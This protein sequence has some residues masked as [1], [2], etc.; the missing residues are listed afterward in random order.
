MWHSRPRLCFRGVRGDS[1]RPSYFRGGLVGPDPKK[2][3]RGLQSALLLALETSPRRARPRKLRLVIGLDGGY[4]FLDSK[5][6]GRG[7]GGGVQHDQRAGILPGVR[8]MQFPLFAGTHD[9]L[10]LG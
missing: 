9:T 10:L 5:K 2:K 8:P 6:Y 3:S 7:P 1:W 4:A